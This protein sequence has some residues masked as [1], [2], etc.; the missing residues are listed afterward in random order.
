MIAWFAGG[1]AFICL[2]LFEILKCRSAVRQ[3]PCFNPWF[4]IGSGLLILSFV[5][6]V[7]H[8][9]RSGWGV[10][11]PGLILLLVSVLLY[12]KVLTVVDQDHIYTENK[13]ILPVV[14]TGPYGVI[15]HPGLWCF[16]AMGAGIGL[17]VPG[18]IPGAVFLSV[19][20]TIYILLQDR[21]FFPVYLEGYDDYRRQV[22]FCIPRFKKS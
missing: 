10:F 19:G 12:I 17:M 15:R 4:Y 21:Y 2:L 7:L 18:A 20:N 22:P 9:E 8:K 5:L 3:K 11:I 16:I 14:S 6:F 13:L 1:A